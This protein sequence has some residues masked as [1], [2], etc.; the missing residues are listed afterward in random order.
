MSP[1]SSF[2]LIAVLGQYFVIMRLQLLTLISAPH[3]SSAPKS[4]RQ[5]CTEFSCTM[6][7][8]NLNCVSAWFSSFHWI[9]CVRQSSICWASYTIAAVQR[10]QFQTTPTIETTRWTEFPHC[11]HWCTLSRCEM[12]LKRN[13]LKSLRMWNKKLNRTILTLL[14]FLWNS[15]LFGNVSLALNLMK[16]PLIS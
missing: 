1:F 9:A 12:M 13:S 14:Y 16:N 7:E 10:V 5:L 4:K 6:V 15:L 8:L 11:Q 2:S 3:C